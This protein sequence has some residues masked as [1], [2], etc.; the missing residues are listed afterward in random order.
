METI[1]G[2]RI[3]RKSAKTSRIFNEKDANDR[4]GLR[5]GS[6]NWVETANQV[7]KTGEFHTYNPSNGSKNI[8]II[9]YESSCSKI[10]NTTT[11]DNIKTIYK[12]P[13]RKKETNNKK[14]GFNPLPIIPLEEG[15]KLLTPLLGFNRDFFVCAPTDTKGEYW[16][17]KFLFSLGSRPET[18]GAQNTVIINKKKV[19]PTHEG[20]GWIGIKNG[21]E[22]GLPRKD[23]DWNLPNYFSDSHEFYGSYIQINFKLEKSVTKFSYVTMTNSRGGYHKQTFLHPT[24]IA[25]FAISSTDN[26]WI[27]LQTCS[28][29]L[30]FINKENQ[31]DYSAATVINL[32][33]DQ[34]FKSKS[35]LLMFTKLEEGVDGFFRTVALADFSLYGIND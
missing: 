3:V 35:W 20:W 29:I 27:H 16:S 8:N 19:K 11:I 21:Y 23:I 31:V 1:D 6:E 25:V 4:F 13:D 17:A 14:T 24:E 22:V 18:M 32:N 26:K 33:H 10:T 12:Y 30:Y 7:L 28:N 5:N 15:I 2:N 34:S 9:D